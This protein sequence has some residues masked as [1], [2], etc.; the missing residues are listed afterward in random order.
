VENWRD[1]KRQIASAVYPLDGV[2]V[3]TD[4]LVSKVI[5]NE[6]KVAVGVELASG[7]THMIRPGGQVVISAGAYRTPQVLMLSGIGHAKDLADFGIPVAVDLPLVGKN[8]HDHLMV[9]RYWK[10]QYPEQG[11]SLGSEL[12]GGENYKKVGQWT[13]LSQHRFLQHH[14]RPQSR[15][16]KDQLGMIIHSL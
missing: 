4:T 6:E 8:L 3:L 14:L 12:F 13:G 1:G 2:R 7:E 16:T 9:F 5:V 11:L 10:L 15:K